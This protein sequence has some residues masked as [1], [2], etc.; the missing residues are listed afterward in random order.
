MRAFERLTKQGKA[1]RLRRLAMTALDGYE[2]EVANVRLIGVHTN[3]LF[4]VGTVGGEKYVIRICQP[5]WRTATDLRSEVMWLQD[6]SCNTD[7]G[8]PVP[9]FT[10]N[11]EPFVEVSVAG[12]PE[13]RRC[14]VTSWIPGASLEDQLTE[15]NLYKM[16]ALFARLH[17]HSADFSP[18]PGFTRRKMDRVL[19]R[20]EADTL[21]GPACNDAFTPRSRDIL[22]RTSERV[23]HAFEQLYADPTHMRVIHN[24]LWHGNIKAHRGVLRP[25]DFEDTIWGYPVQDIAMALHDLMVDVASERYEPL[26]RAFHQG[27]E[28]LCPWPEHRAGQIDTFRAGRM[29]WIAN[30]VACFERQHL[31]RHVDGLATVFERF[32]DTDMIR[33]QERIA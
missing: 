5:G 33:K 31:R 18:P 32:L 19:A 3:I 10:R 21:F 26:Q 25:L 1:R 23:D 6:L 29:L 12:V 4:R 22:E 7:I 11:G 16:G 28:S 15:E 17:A 20:G 13:P 30:Y 24:D 14:V 2:L 9:Q 27:Y 8:A